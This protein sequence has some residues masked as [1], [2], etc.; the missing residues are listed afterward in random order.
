VESKPL[1]VAVGARGAY[2]AEVLR[3]GTLIIDHARFRA[4]LAGAALPLTRL[5][6]DLLTLLA[7]NCGRVVTYSELS[8]RVLQRRAP[9][10]EAAL[11]VHVSHLR[12][13]L[14]VARHCV[15]TVR[16]RGLAFDAEAAI[17]SATD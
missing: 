16:G 1:A 10:G 5:E 7:T 4:E 14:G 9:S 2:A 12:S 8:D 17:A 11:R 15:A 13:K 6:F 3:Y